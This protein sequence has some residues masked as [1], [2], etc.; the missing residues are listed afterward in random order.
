MSNVRWSYLPPFLYFNSP[1]ISFPFYLPLN[2]FFF[3]NFISI[4]AFHMYM[5][6]GCLLELGQFT[7]GNIH[8]E[9]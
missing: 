5:N 4:S 7:K 2:V 8:E 6:E 1:E 3:C 9:N